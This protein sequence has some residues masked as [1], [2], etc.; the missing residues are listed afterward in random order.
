LLSYFLYSSSEAIA[1]DNPGRYHGYK[2]YFYTLLNEYN[3]QLKILSK[4]KAGRGNWS[5]IIYSGKN[6]DL[7]QN[8]RKRTEAGCVL[9]K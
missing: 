3:K 6:I 2:R 9:S 1:K 5:I 8:E 7:F 4:H